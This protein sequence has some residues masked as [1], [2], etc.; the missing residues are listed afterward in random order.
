MTMTTTH[1]LQDQE[2]L[3]AIAKRMKRAYGQMGAVI[4]MLEDDRSC[5]EIVT[6]MAA[7]GKAVNTAAFK[8]I[9]ASL[10]ECIED[11]TV[12]REVVTEKLQKLFLSLA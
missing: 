6:Q 3:S 11:A 2:Q 12:D 7:V 1:V 4:R 8:L 5:E 9:A 10:K